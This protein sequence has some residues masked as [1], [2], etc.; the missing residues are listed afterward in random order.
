MSA[1]VDHIFAAGDVAEARD[2]FTGKPKV[3]AIIPSAVTQGRIAGANMAG[4][5]T[6][7]EGGIPTTAFNFINRNGSVDRWEVSGRF[8]PRRK[9][10]EILSITIHNIKEPGTF[11]FAVFGRSR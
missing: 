3:S 9:N 2:F 7:Y 6:E 4:L 10:N 11:F 5:K 8:N 1:G